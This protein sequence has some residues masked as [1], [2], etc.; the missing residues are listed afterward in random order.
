[1]RIDDLLPKLLDLAGA[2]IGGRIRPVQRLGELTD[3]DRAGG[4]RQALELLEVLAEV[5]AGPAT[6]ERR[7]DEERALNGLLELDDFPGN[8]FLLLT[9]G[10][11]APGGRIGHREVADDG[12]DGH[13]AR[14]TV[15]HAARAE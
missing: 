13:V 9:Q 6:L 12:P 5:V 2:E 15:I 1:M 11:E 10:V 14:N 8:A 7:S 4:V 3:D